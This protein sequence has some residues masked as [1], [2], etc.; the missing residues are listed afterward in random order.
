[1]FIRN[2]VAP[3][4]ILE[5]VFV[6]NAADAAAA[7]TDAECKAFGEAYAKGILKTLGVSEPAKTNTYYRVQVGAFTEKANAEKL[8]QDLKNKGYSGAYIKN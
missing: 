2:T 8:L 3:A 7:D 1:M 5:G 4:V 6:D